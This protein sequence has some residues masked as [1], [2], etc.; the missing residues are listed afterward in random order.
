MLYSCVTAHLNFV[1][2][3]RNLME[4]YRQTHL[5][6]LLF[7]EKNQEMIRSNVIQLQKKCR[8]KVNVRVLYGI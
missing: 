6:Y 2:K 7:E 5:F 1:F 3:D 8:D 4:E